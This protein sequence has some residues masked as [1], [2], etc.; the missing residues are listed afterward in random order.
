MS[1]ARDEFY[2]TESASH[3]APLGWRLSMALCNL[4][5][6]ATILALAGVAAFEFKGFGL[7]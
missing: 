2:A 5:I 6:G 1:P 4:L 3:S 7:F